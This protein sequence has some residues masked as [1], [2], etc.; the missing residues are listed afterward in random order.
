MSFTPIKDRIEYGGCL[1]GQEERDAILRV[2]DSQGMRRWTIGPESE[3]FEKELAEVAGTKY[4]VVC[5]SGSSALLLAISALK[6]PKGSKVIIPALTFPTAYSSLLQNNLIPVVIDCDIDTLNLDI[7]EVNK[8]LEKHKDVQAVVA[9]NIAG[10]CVDMKYLRETIDRHN[11]NIKLVLDNC[12][13]FGGK[14]DGVMIDSLADVSCISMHAAHIISMGEGGAVLTNDKD[15]ADRARKM[16]EWGRASG[17]DTITTQPGFPE[18]YRER[19]VF[20][21]MGYNMKPLE[22]QCAMGRVQLKRLED[23]K[24][25]R[26]LNFYSLMPYFQN[27]NFT[28][29]KKANL[30]DPCWFSFAFI[31]RGV[32]R[33]FVM[34][35]LEKNN[36]EVRTIF[37]GNILRHPAYKDEPHIQIGDLKNC[38]EVMKSGM[39]IGTPPTMTAEMVDFVGS[40][41]K[42]L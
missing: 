8:A 35:Q 16:R 40:I 17:S 33:K 12:D 1:V 18:D 15:V 26:G 19:Y 25:K 22:L 28:T 34:E 21:E 39:F 11:P 6:L 36:I 24:V 38:D 3:L 27:D 5:N 41:I 13:G 14:Y 7:S 31:C 4:G 23:F 30:A 2:I 29:I 10:N 37:S 32:P 42:S 9:I 20:E